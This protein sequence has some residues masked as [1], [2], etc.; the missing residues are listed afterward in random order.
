MFQIV[1]SIS[2]RAHLVILPPDSL[3]IAWTSGYACKLCTS[4]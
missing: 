1:S 3:K 4:H 2:V